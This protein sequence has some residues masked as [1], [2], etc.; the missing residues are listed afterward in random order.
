MFTQ[1]VE[2]RTSDLPLLRLSD[3]DRVLIS[4]FFF[5]EKEIDAAEGEL[6]SVRVIIE[7][8]TRN[9]IRESIPVIKR[10]A[11]RAIKIFV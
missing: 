9:P 4:R 8:Q 2:D 10:C 11:D 6:L 7:P 5:P 3:I 1:A